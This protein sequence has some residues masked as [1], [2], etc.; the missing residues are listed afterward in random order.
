MFENILP[1]YISCDII[2]DWSR[3]SKYFR[4]RAKINFFLRCAA[5]VCITTQKKQDSIMR[6]YLKI[7]KIR[8]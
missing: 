3:P 4:L 1:Y 6:K 5:E 7:P 2:A 8:F